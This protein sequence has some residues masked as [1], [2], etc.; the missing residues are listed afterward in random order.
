[1]HAR[2]PSVHWLGD[3]IE[4]ERY[5]AFEIG[6]AKT[7]AQIHVSGRQW[8]IGCELHDELGTAP[9]CFDDGSRVQALRTPED[10]KTRQCHVTCAQ[11]LQ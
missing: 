5:F 6:N 2:E 7:A 3:G 11:F 9:L 4:I 1:M 10:V 8:Q